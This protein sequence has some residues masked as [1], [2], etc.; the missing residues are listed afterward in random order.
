ML[1][2]AGFRR[3]RGAR[4]GLALLVAVGAGTSLASFCAAWKTDH[5]YPDYLRRADVG[6][7]VVN[8]SLFTAHLIDVRCC[9]RP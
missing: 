7:V 4:A 5:A 8:P 9:A 3:R 1:V 6:H 2:R